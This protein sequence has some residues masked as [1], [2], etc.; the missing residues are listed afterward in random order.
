MWESNM[1]YKTKENCTRGHNLNITRK[2]HPN[3][4][5][6]CSEC[7]AIRQREYREKYPDRAKGYYKTA[8]RRRNYGLE[9]DKYQKLL[10]NSG[11]KCMICGDSPKKRSL[12]IDHCHNTGIIRGLLCHGCNT[13]LGL[14][15]ENI[16]V[17]LKAIKYLEGK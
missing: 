12:H 13:A 9:P 16:S 15:K 5:S 1:A 8:N 7:K 17:M 2:F 4:D 6:Y 10:D 11:N 3:G 14:F